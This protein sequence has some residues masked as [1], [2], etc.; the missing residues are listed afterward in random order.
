MAAT[1]ESLAVGATTNRE[2]QQQPSSSSGGDVRNIIEV[3]TYMYIASKK[4]HST[5]AAKAGSAAM[6]TP[7][8][9]SLTG[10]HQ[11]HDGGARCG[12]SSEFHARTLTAELTLRFDK[13]IAGEALRGASPTHQ[14]TK[15]L[16]HRQHL[17]HRKVTALQEE[18]KC[19]R[20]MHSVS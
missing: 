11:N 7:R 19:I 13:A 18:G 12:M 16:F 5:A 2:Q 15:S 6:M 1:K 8:P 4:Q 17:W 9:H 3:R 20:W 10:P 14:K